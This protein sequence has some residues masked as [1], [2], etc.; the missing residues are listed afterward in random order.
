[1][2]ISNEVVFTVCGLRVTESIVVSWIVIGVILLL[3]FL[4]TRGFKVTHIGKRQAFM[5]WAVTSLQ[6][7]VRNMIG[8]EGERYVGYLVAVLL[9]IGT[10]NIAG[11]FGFD[12]PTKD[13]SITAALALMSIV[14]IQ[15]ASIRH[16]RI[17]GW[18]KGFTK[19]AA[20]VTPINIMEL[21]IRPLSLCMRLFGNVLGA[22]IIMELIDGLCPVGV[23]IIASLYFDFFDGLLQAYVFVFLTSLFIKEG[24]ED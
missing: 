24:L 1:M 9:Y 8:P 13:L 19:P 16:N 5:E 7:I 12:P 14:L 20:L 4:L 11:V 10:C 6:N 23:P 3:S 17:G 2:E 15:A 18:I 22:Y 21:A